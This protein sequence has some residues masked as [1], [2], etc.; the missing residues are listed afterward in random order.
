MIENRDIGIKYTKFYNENNNRFIS[1]ACLTQDKELLICENGSI[2][3]R[4]TYKP[5]NN[6]YSAELIKVTMAENIKAI[7]EYEGVIYLLDNKKK[8]IITYEGINRENIF[9]LLPRE[10]QFIALSISKYGIAVTC[11]SRKIYFY[12]DNNLTKIEIAFV[13]EP[14]HIEQKKE[15]LFLVTDSLNHIVYEVDKRGR[16]QWFFGEKGEPGWDE[17]SIYMPMCSVYGKDDSIY[18]AEQRNHRI[19]HVT[20]EKKIIK[21]LGRCLCVGLTKGRLWAPDFVLVDNDNDHVFAVLSKSGTI[22]QIKHDI[23][24]TIYGY[25]RIDYS[26]FNFQRSCEWN[27]YLHKMLVAD[28]GHNRVLVMD[29]NGKVEKEIMF[30]NKLQLECPRCAVW[31]NDK[32]L[33]T[34]SRNKRVIL[35]NAEYELINEYDFKDFEFCKGSN[36]LQVAMMDENCTQL[37]VS[38]SIDVKVFDLRNFALVWSSNKSQM[39][40]C[41]IHC[42]QLE[43]DEIIITD[44]GNDRIVFINYNKNIHILEHVNMGGKEIRLNRPRMAKRVRLG[45][46]IV[47][48][49]NSKVY[50]IDNE[51]DV[52][53]LFSHGE[54]R[55]MGPNY[56]SAPRWATLSKNTLFI[57]DTDNHRIVVKKIKGDK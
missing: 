22:V 44:T 56:L 57:S 34:D 37:L 36:W 5:M 35:L 9:L 52:N 39:K 26:V 14:I 21:E 16:V 23:F 27:E 31:V 8:C 4:L 20:R 6:K 33:I 55:G 43:N 45:I 15:D 3:K 42:V 7:V 30:I 48:S 49:G 1:G 47:D 19:L 28:T 53:V 54:K 50:I 38:T 17:K 24:N 25:N 11:R 10:E 18:I 29:Q 12:E 32:I 2:L 51:Y 46:L 40:Y 41:D 13:E